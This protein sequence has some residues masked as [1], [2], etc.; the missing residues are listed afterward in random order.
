MFEHQT[1]KTYTLV[2]QMIATLLE[3]YFDSIFYCLFTSTS[4]FPPTL[5]FILFLHAFFLI[6]VKLKQI[7]ESQLDSPIWFPN[8]NSLLIVMYSQFTFIS[9]VTLAAVIWMWSSH[10]IAIH[11]SV[12]TATKWIQFFTAIIT[13]REQGYL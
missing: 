5:L 6:L 9:Y 8:L 2:L 13:D 1:L 4:L 12:N 7:V 3:T 11:F 10:K